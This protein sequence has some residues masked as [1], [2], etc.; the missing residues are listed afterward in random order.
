M[1]IVCSPIYKSSAEFLS[2][3]Y[4]YI[5]NDKTKEIKEI[6]SA[7]NYI[8]PNL[9]VDLEG[10][11]STLSYN[12]TSFIKHLNAL[13]DFFFKDHDYDL[14][15]KTAALIFNGFG[16]TYELLPFPVME[17]EHQVLYKIIKYDKPTNM[18]ETIQ[19][20]DLN[21][22]N[23]NDRIKTRSTHPVILEKIIWLKNKITVL[24]TNPTDNNIKWIRDFLFFVTAKRSLSKNTKITIKESRGILCVAHTCSDTIDIPITHIVFPLTM[25]EET[26]NPRT[27]EQQFYDNLTFS[28]KEAGSSFEN[29]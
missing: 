9:E 22:D 25:N 11:T 5:N 20:I 28:I 1:P 19:G 14:Y 23:F 24:L 13:N 10:T 8:D 15:L 21:A 18:G 12:P 4:D 6:F 27:F 17:G 3:N 2:F 26:I 29:A 16:I 7:I